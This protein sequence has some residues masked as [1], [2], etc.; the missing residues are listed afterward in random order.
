[1]LILQK[2]LLKLSITSQ[3]FLD[4]EDNLYGHSDYN[5]LE[6]LNMYILLIYNYKYM[7]IFNQYC[8]ILKDNQSL[9][10]LFLSSWDFRIPGP[11]GF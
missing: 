6:N 11:L 5:M 9:Y 4:S 8:D 3:T 1:M 7:Y 2:K 10:V